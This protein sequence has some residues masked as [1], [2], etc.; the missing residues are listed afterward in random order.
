MAD[1]RVWYFDD[2]FNTYNEGDV[3]DGLTK[4][5]PPA[6]A[7]GIL[8]YD[9][10]YYRWVNSNGN[11][12][13]DGNFNKDVRV[14]L[15]QAGVFGV[16]WHRIFGRQSELSARGRRKLHGNQHPLRVFVD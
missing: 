5:I 3:T 9:P 14:W 1:Y 15:G 6:W 11:N 12:I 7:C 4:L 2:N 8:F 10:S 13:G 16:A